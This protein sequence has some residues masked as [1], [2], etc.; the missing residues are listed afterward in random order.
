MATTNQQIVDTAWFY[1]DQG[2]YNG[3]A[4]LCL[5]V[6]E[7]GFAP[8]QNLMGVLYANGRGVEKNLETAIEWYTKAAE[9]GYRSSMY[10]LGRIYD[11]GKEVERDTEKAFYWL[12]KAAN[13]G[14]GGSMLH[15]AGLYGRGEG[16]EE[17]QELAV[18]WLVKA[19]QNGNEQA[20]LQL[21]MMMLNTAAR[22][23][24][25]LVLPYLEQKA[26]QGDLTAG[27]TV[28]AA[29]RYGMNKIEKNLKKAL[30]WYEQMAREGDALSAQI[31]KEIMEK[32]E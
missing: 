15:L 5:P 23:Y 18:S 7:S 31:V 10:N 28:A 30:F 8:A 25:Y 20:D 16:V 17:N 24:T 29:Y 11:M 2:D 6:A 1:H 26:V 4:A 32:G 3:A 27:G 9:S 19:A 14:H 21:E 12:E 22:E 13:E